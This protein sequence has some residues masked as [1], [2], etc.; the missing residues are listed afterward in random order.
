MLADLMQLLTTLKICLLVEVATQLQGEEKTFKEVNYW[1]VPHTSY[2]KWVFTRRTPYVVLCNSSNWHRGFY[3]L[4][5]EHVRNDG[6][7]LAPTGLSQ[8]VTTNATWSTFRREVLKA[9][10][11]S[12]SRFSDKLTNSNHNRLVTKASW[13][14]EMQMELNKESRCEPRSYFRSS[15]IGTR[16][17]H[18]CTSS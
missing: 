5:S 1:S 16:P 13:A 3:Y 11:S 7:S 9:S 4:C 14:L 12:E 10:I 17:S 8:S 18:T 2:V 15:P 6:K